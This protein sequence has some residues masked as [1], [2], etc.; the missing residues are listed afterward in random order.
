MFWTLS[1]YDLHIPRQAYDRE[2]TQVKQKMQ[3]LEQDAGRDMVCKSVVD[4]NKKFLKVLDQNYYR[5]I[6]RLALIYFQTF[7]N[8]LLLH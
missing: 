8:S 2:V 7:L 1:A 3:Q 4:Q 6:V 5:V